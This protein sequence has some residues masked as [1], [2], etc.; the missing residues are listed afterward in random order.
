MPGRRVSLC[1]PPPEACPALVSPACTLESSA[2]SAA[3][4]KSRACRSLRPSLRW[5]PPSSLT[6]EQPARARSTSARAA[7][8]RLAF[9]YPSTTTYGSLRA[10]SRPTT[11][12][13]EG[14]RRAALIAS[15]PRLSIV[16]KTL[17]LFS[18]LPRA[19]SL[20]CCG[21]AVL[22]LLYH[23][24]NG[25]IGKAFEPGHILQRSH[26]TGQR[27]SHCSHAPRSAYEEHRPTR[28]GSG[29]VSMQHGM[30]RFCRSDSNLTEFSAAAFFSSM[31]P[32]CAESSGRLSGRRS[33]H[34]LVAACHNRKASPSVSASATA[35]TAAA[36]MAAAAAVATL[37]VS[38]GSPRNFARL[39]S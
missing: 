35:A 22:R 10:R 26:A 36:A 11:S 29:H 14:H 31:V 37:S 3:N 39:P 17:A 16:A 6:S 9:Q 21:D 4:G 33:P 15:R 28:P 20:C 2:N 7:L 38:R 32:P 19:A 1:Q 13:G 34:Q 5:S 8:V 24:G 18:A 23:S 12:T 30:V 25:G 27:A